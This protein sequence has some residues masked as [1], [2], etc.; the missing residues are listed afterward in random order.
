MKCTTAMAQRNCRY[1]MYGYYKMNG[2]CEITESNIY[3]CR[4]PK[5][6]SWLS[7]KDS[8]QHY[9]KKRWRMCYNWTNIKYCKFP[10]N[11]V[12]SEY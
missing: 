11:I 6:V 4:I 5:V 3:Y 7:F 2:R 9:F 12:R 8:L 10:Q 1:L